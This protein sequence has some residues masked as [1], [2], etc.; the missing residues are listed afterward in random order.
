[1]AAGA[2]VS[3]GDGATGVVARRAPVALVVEDVHWADSAT[4][5]CLTCLARADRGQRGDGGG[6]LPRS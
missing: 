3:R 2:A 4:L 1:V 5:D 6:H